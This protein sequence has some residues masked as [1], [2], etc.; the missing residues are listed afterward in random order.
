M[1]AQ[2]GEE[3]RQDCQKD[4]EGPDESDG[5]TLDTESQPIPSC[6]LRYPSR[7]PCGRSRSLSYSNSSSRLRIGNASV[8]QAAASRTI[9]HAPKASIGAK[10]CSKEG[11]QRVGLKIATNGGHCCRAEAALQ[12]V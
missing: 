10:V 5:F 3:Q 4:C 12:C 11:S 6:L 9:R 1:N 8:C 7:P 2:A